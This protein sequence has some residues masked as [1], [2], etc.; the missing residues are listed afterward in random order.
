MKR[1]FSLALDGKDDPQLTAESRRY[2]GKIWPEV[3]RSIK[4]SGI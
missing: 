2:Q 4:D 3:A 1:L